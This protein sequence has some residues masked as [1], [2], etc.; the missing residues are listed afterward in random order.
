MSPYESDDLTD[1]IETDAGGFVLLRSPDTAE[2]TP[3]YYE[4]GTFS[5]RQEAEAH[6]ATL[7]H[8]DGPTLQL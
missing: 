1:V 5:T 6:L 2:H 4:V 8:N 7:E 3:D